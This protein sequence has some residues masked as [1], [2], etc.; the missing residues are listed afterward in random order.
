[1]KK[2][3]AQEWLL[4]SRGQSALNLPLLQ[5]LLF[6]LAQEW[7]VNFDIDEYLEFLDILYSRIIEKVV[8]GENDKAQVS[9][10]VYLAHLHLDFPREEVVSKEK[11]ERNIGKQDLAGWLLCEEDEP[12]DDDYNYRYIEDKKEMVLR[13][14]KKRKDQDHK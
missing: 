6:R 8:V 2:E 4:D 14:Y 11:E 5:K 12:V 1:M 13:K 10:Q 9:S 3:I 7:A